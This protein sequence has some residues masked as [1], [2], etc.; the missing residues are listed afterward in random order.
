MGSL[1]ENLIFGWLPMILLGY[2][3]IC[4]LN[5]HKRI[6]AQSVLILILIGTTFY[7]NFYYPVRSLENYQSQNIEIQIEREKLLVDTLTAQFFMEVEDAID[8]HVAIKDENFLALNNLPGLVYYTG[9]KSPSVPLYLDFPI[10]EAMNRHNLE[11]SLKFVNGLHKRSD[12]K[13][14]LMNEDVHPDLAVAVEK[15]LNLSNNYQKVAR[16]L[17][18]YQGRLYNPHKDSIFSNIYIRKSK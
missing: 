14:V 16:I 7:F 2:V 13:I 12:I 3:F 9:H 1:E 4:N 11:H 15:S 18:P 10:A 17:N 6:F 8:K 5:N